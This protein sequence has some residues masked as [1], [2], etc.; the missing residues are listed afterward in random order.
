[1]VW[2]V[3]QLVW[4]T[5]D[6]V[7]S[8]DISNAVKQTMRIVFSQL[9][10]PAWRIASRHSISMIAKDKTWGYRMFSS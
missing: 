2:Q 1:M 3:S 8:F 5:P 6:L 10:S 9:L 7:S 4:L